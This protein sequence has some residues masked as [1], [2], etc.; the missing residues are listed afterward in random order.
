[1]REPNLTQAIV[2]IEDDAAAA[3]RR[4]TVERIREAVKNADGP[5]EYESA[6]WYSHVLAILDEEAQR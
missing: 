5:T 1:V 6:I 4:A 2:A 3:E